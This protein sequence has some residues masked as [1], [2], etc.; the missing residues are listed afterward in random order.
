M[1]KSH[2]SVDSSA[3]RRS[4]LKQSTG[5]IAAATLAS[6]A[7]HAHAAEDDTVRIALVGCGG[8]G[9]G[10]AVNALA[11]TGNTE[12]VAL[13]DVFTDRVE[14]T[15]TSLKQQFGAK[16][17]V[18]PDRR[19]IGLDAYRK[20]VDTLGKNDVIILATP[21]GFRPLHFEYAVAQG[22]NVFMEK[23][24]G[25]D[26]PGVRRILKAGE[27]ARQ[28]NLK[29]ATGL[30]WRH[31]PAREEAI[32]RIHDGALG[33]LIL[34]RTYRMHGAVG[35]RPK[36]P[37]QSELAYQ[38]ANYNSFHWLG[39]S[40]FVDWLIHNIDICCWA[41]NALPV[42]AQGQAGRQ[43]RT[44][45]DQIFDHYMVEYT[46]PDG[47]KLLAQGRH[48]DQCYAVFSDFAQGTKG[49]AILMADLSA[50]NPRFYNNHIQTPANQTW[51]YDGP[52]PNPYQ[53]EHDL[54]FD[55]IRNNKSYN[56]TER[57]AKACLV[58]LMG[59]MAAHSGQ[60]ITWDQAMAS[61]LELAPNLEKLTWD[62][63]APVMPDAQGR[64]PMPVPGKTREF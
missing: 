31:D 8:R 5:A 46:F 40:F 33:D 39:A 58:A 15:H 37:G 51:R 36:Q 59:R 56:E 62:S 57:S 24:F 26:A 47:T 19:F 16:V 7:T 64:Y 25:V 4:F 53:V 50:A 29:V 6:V 42:S 28:K 20:A 30:M 12:L 27:I 21:A 9:T 3:S 41:K 11:T 32:K 60:L 54:L 18:P 14:A 55:A 10:A 48:I 23:S 1:E 13:A 34:L 17:N 38:L 22:R 44:V 61:D 52:T 2:L 63:D 43:T 35:Y 45:N 49:S